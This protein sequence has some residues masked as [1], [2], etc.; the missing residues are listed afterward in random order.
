MGRGRGEDNKWSSFTSPHTMSCWNGFARVDEEDL[1]LTHLIGGRAEIGAK[2]VSR[3]W[4]TEDT[5]K[6]HGWVGSERFL[7]WRDALPGRSWD[8]RYSAIVRTQFPSGKGGVLLFSGC[9]QVPS[10]HVPERQREKQEI[11]RER[12]QE[13]TWNQPGNNVDMWGDIHRR[14]TQ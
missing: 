8:I 13:D 1:S 7:A 4:D 2:Q 14:R 3:T 5:E 11:F 6:G 9:H 12:L 10:S